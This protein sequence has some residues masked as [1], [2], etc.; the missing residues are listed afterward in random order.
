M[1]IV[2]AI[3]INSDTGAW[4]PG[5]ASDDFKNI[6]MMDITT[7]TPGMYLSNDYGISWYD[8]SRNLT[9]QGSS[10]SNTWRSICCSSD[11][12]KLTA[13][14][15][16]GNIWT[17]SDYGIT[18]NKNALS[19]KAWFCVCGSIDMSK[20]AA[21]VNGGNIW[22]STNS[23]STWSDMAAAGNRTWRSI[24]CSSDFTKL[25]AVVNGGNIFTSNN[26]GS[27]WTDRASAGTRSWR[28][29]A[30]SSD[31]GNLVATVENT[32]SGN[33]VISR[34]SGVTWT[35]ITLPVN[36]SK[37]STPVACSSD[38]KNIIVGSWQSNNLIYSTDYGY[39][40][41]LITNNLSSWN[42]CIVKNNNVLVA[43]DTANLYV[44]NF[45]FFDTSL[46]TVNG[47][48]E[49][50]FIR[51]YPVMDSTSGV[52]FDRP[53]SYM[54]AFY[55]FNFSSGT[56]DSWAAQASTGL[57]PNTGFDRNSANTVVFKNL[58]SL[59]SPGNVFPNGGNPSQVVLI[60]NATDSTNA[61]YLQT[62]LHLY[63][64]NISISFWINPLT[65]AIVDKYICIVDISPG[66]S[67]G[68][69]T[70]MID[71]NG[72]QIVMF[73]NNAIGTGSYAFAPQVIPVNTWTHVV[74]M[75]NSITQIGTIYINGVYSAN[76]WYGSGAVLNYINTTFIGMKYG[77]NSN[78]TY[79]AYNG[80]I[81]FYNVFNR[82]LTEYEVKYLYNNPGQPFSNINANSLSQLYGGVDGL[83]FLRGQAEFGDSLYSRMVKK[84]DSPAIYPNLAPF[85][86]CYGVGTYT[87]TLR[88]GTNRVFILV[89][90]GGGG[91][92]GGNYL[93]GG[94]AGG[95]GGGGGGGGMAYYVDEVSNSSTISVTVGAG[96]A[97]GQSNINLTGGT[98]P[99]Y[100]LGGNG[101]NGGDSF[102]NINSIEVCR[103][104]GGARA[105][106][107]NNPNTD[108]SV[109]YSGINSTMMNTG[110]NG[111]VYGG[112]TI[113]VSSLFDNG[114]IN[115]ISGTKG[116]DSTS[117]AFGT[118][119]GG[120]FSSGL[121]IGGQD[122][123]YNYGGTYF[124][125]S[126]NAIF[127]SG[128][129]LRNFGKGG[130]GG[131]GEGGGGP[132]AG[133]AGQDGAVIIFE[134]CF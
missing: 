23:G 71:G 98:T 59:T 13:V 63:F 86:T 32:T 90:G 118:G 79:K 128:V 102:I 9:T 62:N 38:F 50:T 127:A 83:P 81:A 91:G 53:L 105:K 1:S 84:Y 5:C 115:G 114:G 107:P 3:P 104:S 10:G 126:S 45:G 40:W 100:Y 76:T 58:S 69:I 87:H 52:L 95:C 77:N 108:T 43:R 57:D 33:V 54:D 116:G 109:Y 35:N 70:I 82:V 122:F 125:T 78:S 121:T 74:C 89:I 111:G 14:R 51:Y 49:Q 60:P 55:Q 106:H 17:S 113:S 94:T 22:I 24:C 8:S 21:V 93:N 67:T 42:C 80:H 129:S 26:S 56:A 92:G 72:K 31:G 6:A 29:I 16:N 39:N 12:L 88:T 123:I 30:C 61:S 41:T 7:G 65:V 120:G 11:F 64:K 112:Y 27:A 2:F 134:Y 46:Y 19:S 18:W 124:L 68:V 131:T 73:I 25:A 34:D 47:V 75:Y 103:A 133:S 97:G 119:G 85:Y 66:T 44:G 15:Q 110:G 130:N 37:S 101:I 132:V 4:M 20:Q 117:T 28:Y 99:V 36:A 96:G 48:S